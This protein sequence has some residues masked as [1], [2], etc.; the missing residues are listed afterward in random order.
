MIRLGGAAMLTL[1]LL[2]LLLAVLPPIPAAPLLLAAMLCD[3]IVTGLWFGWLVRLAMLALPMAGQ[4]V[5]GMIGM[6]NV[7][8]PDALLG[9]GTSALSRLF[10]LAVVV[11][12]FASGLWS[13]PIRALADLYSLLPPGQTIPAGDSAQATIAA[14]GA[15]LALALRLAAP[16]I[17]A[18]LVYHTALALAGKLVP[19][20]QLHFAAAPGQL[21]G[22]IA[23]LGLL[24][25][26]LFEVWQQ[27]VREIF[28]ALPGH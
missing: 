26:L 27:E 19:H 20:L 3:E 13:V 11:L 23:L 16:F 10:G 4:I 2:P 28:A 7:I 21:L 14:A 24:V 12:V 1:V 8:Q 5:A 9:A 17:L 18:G 6:M 15:A 22:G 25:P